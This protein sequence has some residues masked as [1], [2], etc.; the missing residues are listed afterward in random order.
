MSIHN[1]TEN[2]VINQIK[3]LNIPVLWQNAG[4][5]YK[6]IWSLNIDQLRIALQYQKE[7]KAYIPN[8]NPDNICCVCLKGYPK[9]EPFPKS[10]GGKCKRCNKITY[11]SREC[12]RKDWK[13]H[14]V[15]CSK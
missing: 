13:R 11:C 14:R 8:K 5:P 15:S 1:N 3:S 2:E 4:D 12:Q 9:K 6:R 7:N 10:G